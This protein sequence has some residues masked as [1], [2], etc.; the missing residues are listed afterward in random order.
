MAK[1]NVF[2]SPPEASPLFTILAKIV[3]GEHKKSS[4]LGLFAEPTPIFAV[5]KDN[6]SQKQRQI[7]NIVFNILTI[8]TCS[9][10]QK[11]QPGLHRQTEL[12]LTNP[13][14]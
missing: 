14:S 3:K 5:C 1:A 10:R 7:E 8:P 12:L 11:K 13:I 2:S 4:S 9:L 6:E